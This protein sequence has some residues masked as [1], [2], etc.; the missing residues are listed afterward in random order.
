ML[1]TEAGSL[2]EGKVKVRLEHDGTILDVDEDDV[3]KVRPTDNSFLSVW[4]HRAGESLPLRL[5]GLGRLRIVH[6]CE[7]KRNNIHTSEY[8]ARSSNEYTAQRVRAFTKTKNE[9]NPQ[10]LLTNNHVITQAVCAL[11]YNI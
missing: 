9:L 3:E 8:G 4:L 10:I 11:Q 2:P 5:A 6:V 1:K 7:K